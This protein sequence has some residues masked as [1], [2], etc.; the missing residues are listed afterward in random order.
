[1]KQL[2]LDFVDRELYPDAL[3]G[4]VNAEIDRLAKS[5]IIEPVKFSDWAAPIVPAV[6]TDDPYAFVE[7]IK[8]R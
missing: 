5:G 2:H 8:P 4:K 1:M 6:K 7:T 3:R